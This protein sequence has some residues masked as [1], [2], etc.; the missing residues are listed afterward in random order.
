[1]KEMTINE[2]VEM[3]KGFLDACMK[4][5][6]NMLIAIK[7]DDPD[8]DYESD[9][10]ISMIFYWKEQIEIF[11]EMVML[12]VTDLFDTR[13]YKFIKQRMNER[14]K[15]F[16][17]EKRSFEEKED[18]KNNKADATAAETINDDVPKNDFSIKPNE[19]PIESVEP[20]LDLVTSGRLSDES[21]P[22]SELNIQDPEVQ[23]KD[24]TPIPEVDVSE[25]Q[26]ESLPS[27]AISMADKPESTAIPKVDK[28][29]KK[30]IWY[31]NI[32]QLEKLFKYLHEHLNID[33]NWKKLIKYHFVYKSGLPITFDIESPDK[34]FSPTQENKIQC[35]G[36]KNVF[37]AIFQYLSQRGLIGRHWASTI[38][39]HFIDKDKKEMSRLSASAFCGTRNFITAINKAEAY[40]KT[41]LGL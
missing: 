21:N 10:A 20:K 17:D 19:N 11:D 40:L 29:D 7:E 18:I 12:W 23:Y 2:Y 5:E 31:G 14:L 38:E 8:G 6:R 35:S 9:N 26:E 24:L 27:N 4:V 30:I 25:E 33:P 15:K 28:K 3:M 36:D 32:N 13:Q 39:P 34:S 41:E 16:E 22:S 37:A 1:M